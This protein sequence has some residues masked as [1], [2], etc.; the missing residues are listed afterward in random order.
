MRKKQEDL[1]ALVERC[2]KFTDKHGEVLNRGFEGAIAHLEM[3]YRKDDFRICF[4]YAKSGRADNGPID[5]KISRGSRT[6]LKASGSFGHGETKMEVK[7][8]NPKELKKIA[9]YIK[10]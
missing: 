7:V 10:H 4:N 8:Y 6:V 9:S 2:I 1:T 5:V 3:E